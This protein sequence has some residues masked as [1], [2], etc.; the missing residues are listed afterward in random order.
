LQAASLPGVVNLSDVARTVSVPPGEPDKARPTGRRVAI[1]V[2]PRESD[3]ARMAPEAFQDGISRLRA[4]AMQNAQSD[5]RQRE[6]RQ[7][8][9]WYGLLVMVVSLAAEGVIGRRLG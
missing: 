9:W 6:D 2:D 3:P 4:A 8:L 5:A 7:F 1:N